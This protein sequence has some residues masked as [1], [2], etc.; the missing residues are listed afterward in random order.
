MKIQG[1]FLYLYA[2]TI[3][4]GVNKQL[5]SC[6]KLIWLPCLGT[7]SHTNSFTALQKKAVASGSEIQI[8]CFKYSFISFIPQPR[9]YK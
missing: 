3:N 4:E 7:F 2:D 5:C 6:I 1:Y 9:T 8:C